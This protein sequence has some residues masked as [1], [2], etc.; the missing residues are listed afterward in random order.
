MMLA[1]EGKSGMS[2]ITKAQL[3][4]EVATL[5]IIM[6]KRKIWLIDYL[7]SVEGNLKKKTKQ[8]NPVQAFQIVICKQ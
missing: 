8:N 6:Q 3:T 7:L 2:G 5:P 4:D 1:M